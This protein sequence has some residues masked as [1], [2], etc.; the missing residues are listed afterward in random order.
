MSDRVAKLQKTFGAVVRS[1]REAK[2]LSQEQLAE[3]SDLSLNYIGNVERGEKMTS[4]DTIVRLSGALG[5]TGGKL[6]SLAKL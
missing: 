3:K 5:I 6:L 4:L 2:A 1:E